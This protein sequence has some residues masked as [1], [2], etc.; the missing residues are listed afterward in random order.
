MA[1]V[2]VARLRG[3]VIVSTEIEKKVVNAIDSPDHFDF[4]FSDASHCCAV[5]ELCYCTAIISDTQGV[6]VDGI[7]GQ[8]PAEKIVDIDA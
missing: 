3:E 5:I 4:S 6:E 2:S 7:S 8:A 1:A